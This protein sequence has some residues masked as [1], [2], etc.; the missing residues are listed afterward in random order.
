M[1]IPGVAQ[2]K[3]AEALI[4]FDR[5]HRNTPEFTGWES[6]GTQRYAIVHNS[7]L[8]P[9]KMIISLA[10]GVR[11]SEFSGGHQSNSYLAKRGFRV[12][13]L[14]ID[15]V[16]GA[17]A[18]SLADQAREDAVENVDGYEQEGQALS[19]DKSCLKLTLELYSFQ[20]KRP[21]YNYLTA[22]SEL[23]RNGIY[24][25]FE[26]GEQVDQGVE[27]I[28]RVGTHKV[29]ERF[30]GRIRQHYGSRSSLK[31]NKNASVF[32]KHVGGALLR[33]DYPRDERLEEWLRPGGR[34]YPDIETRVSEILRDNFTF[35]CFSVNEQEER[36][37]FE[38]GIIALLAR[39]PLGRPSADWLGSYA[40]E[41]KIG[42]SGLWNTQQ[43]EAE[44]LS[45]EQVE[46]LRKLN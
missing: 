2:G 28:V 29:D 25:F 19:G 35:C 31:G 16:K 37:K 14:L 39:Y 21:R 5:K 26:K 43:L 20:I 17:K 23:P 30:R 15:D 44:P 8:Y 1:V 36:L 7:K 4:T 46:Y 3:I 33:R 10:T 22:G 32:R 45:A 6:K 38:R 11:R 27:R 13:D 24:F 12:I 18:A 42:R 40:H 41:R 34:T 9:P